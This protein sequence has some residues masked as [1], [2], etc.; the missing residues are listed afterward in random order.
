MKLIVI[1]VTVLLISG[2]LN[3]AQ[4]YQEQIDAYTGK[5]LSLVV[6]EFG[7]PTEIHVSKKSGRLIYSYKK[8]RYLPGS[9][10]QN[11]AGLNSQGQAVMKQTASSLGRHEYCYTSFLL[12]TFSKAEITEQTKVLGSAHTGNKCKEVLVWEHEVF[13]FVKSK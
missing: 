12:D 4:A 7:E 6:A 1:L 9:P 13:N 5:T 3:S 11:V 10:P 2:C 8:H